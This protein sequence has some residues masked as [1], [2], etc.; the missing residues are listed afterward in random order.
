[1]DKKY[2]IASGGLPINGKTIFKKLIYVYLY[3]YDLFTS[4]R[5]KKRLFSPINNP[6]KI[7]ISNI[8][9]LG[10]VIVTT[11][12]IPIIKKHYPN[13]Q[14]FFLG[15]SNTESLIKNHN[16]IDGYFCFD[17]MRHNRKKINYL[18]KI[19]IHFQ[20]KRL[21]IAQL[22]KEK[23]D[24]AI[25]FF[26]VNPNSVKLLHKAKIPNILGYT[27]GGY[28]N[29]LTLKLDKKIN[30]F[31]HMSEYHLQLVNV[32]LE[33]KER[34]RPL[35]PNLPYVKEPNY[36]PLKNYENKN[37][38]LIHSGAGQKRRYLNFDQVEKILEVVSQDNFVLFTGSGKEEDQHIKK[39]I[40]K[41]PNCINLSNKLHVLDL[42]YLCNKAR[43]VISTDSSI[44]HIASCFDNPQIVL[45]KTSNIV[46]QN[47]WCLKKPNI[48]IIEN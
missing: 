7:L 36:K 25:D 3:F 21:L 47:L 42:I 40:K 28:K 38:V 46:H 19:I 5:E 10:D 23:I 35:E 12:I 17:H 15:N 31:W 18:K 8:A 30:P 1:M 24:L 22:K 33:E 48:E 44:S 2:I 29:L 4:Y 34:I 41:K 20:T 14:L 45:Y 37:F 13:A 11:S 6:K 39:L 43:M 9:H 27:N 32:V 16:L 26:F